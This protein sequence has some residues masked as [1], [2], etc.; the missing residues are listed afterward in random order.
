MRATQYVNAC[1]LTVTWHCMLEPLHVFLTVVSCCQADR[2]EDLKDLLTKF[3]DAERGVN[4][5]RTEV[6]AAQVRELSSQL[7]QVKQE[8][9][10]SQTEIQALERRLVIGEQDWSA[11]R[12]QLAQLSGNKD[13]ETDG[14]SE[15]LEA[16]L[17]RV[18]ASLAARTNAVAMQRASIS[19]LVNV[20]VDSSQFF[21]NSLSDSD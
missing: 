21:D 17:V 3:S 9:Q 20:F 16:E 4:Q 2:I 10:I 7:H 12:E 11:P 18:K 14:R 15:A 5:S 1:L 8:L 19:E 6:S 13:T